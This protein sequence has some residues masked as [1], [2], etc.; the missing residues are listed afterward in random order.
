MGRLDIEAAPGRLLAVAAG[1]LN[2]AGSAAM[3]GPTR[4]PDVDPTALA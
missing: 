2:G 4:V 1:G 3:T